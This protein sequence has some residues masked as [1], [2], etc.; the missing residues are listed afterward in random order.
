M[1]VHLHWGKRAA[2]AKFTVR[3]K[4]LEEA[5]EALDARGDDEWGSF[6]SDVP[7]KTKTGADGNVVWVRIAPSFTLTMPTWPGYRK[8]PQECKDEWDEMWVALKKHENEHRRQFEE[9]IN[10]LVTDLKALGPTTRE[11]C[12][13]EMDKAI[14]AIQKEHDAYDKQTDH[15]RSRGVELTITERCRSKPKR[16]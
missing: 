16:Q 3:A 9:G 8:Q 7:Y 4:S 14:A 12:E 2:N 15:G 10:K 6:V 11:K 5:R 1:K 13:E